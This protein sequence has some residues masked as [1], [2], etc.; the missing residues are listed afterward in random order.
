MAISIPCS[1]NSSKA[2]V[3]YASV[4]NSFTLKSSLVRKI[5][6]T[7]TWI[8][9][10]V[11]VNQCFFYKLSSARYHISDIR[12]FNI[13]TFFSLNIPYLKTCFINDDSLTIGKDIFMDFFLLLDT[14][15]YEQ[16]Y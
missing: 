16:S 2:Q 7:F 4:V 8:R 1:F 11:G 3:E 15:S 10:S 6:I 9:V 14:N 5:S 12:F 13:L